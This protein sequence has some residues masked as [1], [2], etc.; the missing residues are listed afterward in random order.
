[1]KKKL[2]IIL[3]A[4]LGLIAARFAISFLMQLN[5]ARAMKSNAVPPVTV[6]EIEN[7][8]VQIKITAPARVV[9]QYRVDVVARINGYLTKSYF[10]EGDYAKKGQVLFEIEPEQ[11]LYEMQEA[12]ANVEAIRAKLIYAQKQLERTEILLKKDYVSKASYDEIL[13]N[14]D[15][16]KNELALNEAKYRDAKR[17]YGY[18]HIKAPVSGRVGM[19]ETTVGNYVSGSKLTTIYSDDP[20]Y[21]TFPVSAK[22]FAYIL[23][24]D[25]GDTKAQRKVELYLS[26]GERYEL[27]GVQDY[28]DNSVDESA[29][30][31]TMRATFKNPNG[32][33]IN[34]DYGTVTMY[35]NNKIEAPMVPM[36]AVLENPQGK[37][38]YKIGDDSIPKMAYIEIQGQEG[39]NYVVESGLQ[40]GDRIITGGLQKVIADKPV[41]V[42]NS[43]EL[44]QIESEEN[45]DKK[46]KD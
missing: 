13:A 12:K 1:M 4:I 41:R 11:W 32:K 44:A 17:N 33:L 9:S 16:L 15:S 25:N 22:T 31:L 24:I 30:T 38:V 5:M 26:N 21:V 19:I 10:K 45:Q 8:L 37:Y 27:D 7:G 40:A 39:N 43:A 20:I 42:V 35:T 28:Y 29:G 46:K 6:G 14:R 23:K 3:L 18:T 34:G 2:I 36:T